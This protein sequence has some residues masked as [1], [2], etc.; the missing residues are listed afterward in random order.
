MDPISSLSVAAAVIQFVD[1]GS[2]LLSNSLQ[3][4][5]SPSGQTAA[6]V[7]LSDISNDLAQLAEEVARHL[8]LPRHG[9]TSI[10]QSQLLKLCGD[11]KELNKELQASV[12]R[13]RAKRVKDRSGDDGI[14]QTEDGLC[15]LAALRGILA[16]PK[17]KQMTER[18]K[19]VRKQMMMAMLACLW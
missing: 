4:Y 7:S 2:R 5:R 9:K 15:L 8:S 17:I 6:V 1:F 19:D 16:E 14:V 10:F 12:H 13:I 11:C 18:M 3:I